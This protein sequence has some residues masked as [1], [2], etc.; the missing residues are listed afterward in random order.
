MRVRT[1]SLNHHSAPPDMRR[2]YAPCASSLALA[3]HDRVAAGLHS[4]VLGAPP[5]LGQDK[6]AVRK[7][8][9]ADTLEKRALL[10]RSGGQGHQG[11]AAR[12]EGL[13]DSG[14]RC[15]ARWLAQRKNV[16]L[17]REAQARAND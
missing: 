3:Y 16:P 17:F 11:Q 6:L 15:F 9:L 5:I 12:P 7:A 10:V 14:L 8:G 1:L 13:A 2:R 4:L